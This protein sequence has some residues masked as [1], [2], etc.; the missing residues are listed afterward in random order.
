MTI[1]FIQVETHENAFLFAYIC[2]RNFNLSPN[3]E[4]KVVFGIKW[5][6]TNGRQ[7][8]LLI[9]LRLMSDNGGTKSVTY[10]VASIQQT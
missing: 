5:T 2:R 3:N 1:C 6:R 8:G 9:L 10:R 7:S 4:F